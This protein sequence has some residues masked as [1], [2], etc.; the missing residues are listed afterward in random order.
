MPRGRLRLMKMAQL[1]WTYK[2]CAQAQNNRDGV[3]DIRPSMRITDVPSVRT[4][5]G[6]RTPTKQ[7]PSMF[8]SVRTHFVTASGGGC[9][10]SLAQIDIGKRFL[11]A[12]VMGIANAA[13]GSRQP[14]N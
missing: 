6:R 12:V 13:L 14:A 11:R 1:Q 2:G 3:Q 9:Q 4:T 7:V 10:E 5:F 8:E